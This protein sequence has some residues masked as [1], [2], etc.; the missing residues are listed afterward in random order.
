MSSFKERFYLVQ[1]LFLPILTSPRSIR[2][3]VVGRPW[4]AVRPINS[5]W[6]DALHS[7]YSCYSEMLLLPQTVQL[8]WRTTAVFSLKYPPGQSLD[9]RSELNI[10]CFLDYWRCSFSLKASKERRTCVRRVSQ[11]LTGIVWEGKPVPLFDFI[12]VSFFLQGDSGPEG[13]RGL[14]GM[15]GP[16]V[17]H[18]WTRVNRTKVDSAVSCPT[19]DHHWPSG[20]FSVKFRFSFIASLRFLTRFPCFP[21]FS[22]TNGLIL[23]PSLYPSAPTPLW[24]GPAGRAGLPGLKGDK[25]I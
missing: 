10:F 14:P 19:H 12:F 23:V 11:P 17:G 1:P 24:Q 5:N 13:L 22:R 18:T 16:Q 3:D 15:V 21:L 7:C 20:R 2:V 8:Y 9:T 4:R 25:V 6:T